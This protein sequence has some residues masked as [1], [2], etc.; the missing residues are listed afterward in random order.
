MH[1]EEELTRK[2]KADLIDQKIS[3]FE[4]NF[5]NIESYMEEL[6]DII[7]SKL[8]ETHFEKLNA[9]KV[10]KV[11][12]YQ[13]LPDN[14]A[15]QQQTEDMVKGKLAEIYQNISEFKMQLDQKMVKIRKDFD[16]DLLKKQIEKKASIK[17]LD[18]TME[19]FEAKIRKLD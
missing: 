16:I 17:S 13:Y 2:A 6:Q 10:S 14:S 9:E 4:A 8:D 18:E 12:I 1:G 19:N 7:D 5:E 11:E 15:L 3:E